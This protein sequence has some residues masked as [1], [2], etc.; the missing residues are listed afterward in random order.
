MAAVFLFI[1]ITS[2]FCFNITSHIQQTNINNTHSLYTM[3]K[4]ANLN[5]LTEWQ[6]NVN[7][8]TKLSKLSIPGTHNSAAFHTASLPSVQCQ[9]ASITEQLE[10][11]VRFLDV[12]LG[13]KPLSNVIST[14]TATITGT[15]Q[16]TSSSNVD[17]LFVVHSKFP[18]KLP[19]STRLDEVLDEVYTFLDKHKSETVLLSLK[20][21]GEGNWEGDDFPNLVWRKYVE[22][23]KDKYYLNTDIPKL[24]DVRGKIFLFRRFGIKNNDQLNSH[25]G[26]D[27][28]WWDYNTTNDDRGSFA[29]QDWCEINDVNDIKK[30]AE[31]VK[32]QAK[33]A[34]DY[35]KSNDDKLFVNFCSGANF[36]NTD[37]WPSKVAKGLT[38]N[39]LENSFGP[40]SGVIVLD[41]AADDEWSNVRA[42]VG[43]NF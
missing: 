2:V 39:G 32:N 23:K 19:T 3:V 29:V 24:G 31:Y 26:F 42:L 35:N 28:H 37:C 16:N 13:R 27:A 14:I 1:Y 34:T 43:Q 12:R 4:K 15:P 20:Q 11:G 41:F 40:S 30:K 17:E 36:Y 9:N 25:F 6:K 7:D 5:E 33:R 8:N 18:V 38:E 22:P 10:H 21:E